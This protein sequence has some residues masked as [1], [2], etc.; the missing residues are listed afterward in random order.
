MESVGSPEEEFKFNTPVSAPYIIPYSSPYKAAVFP[1]FYNM[2]TFP[3]FYVTYPSPE[4]FSLASSEAVF[5]ACGNKGGG[6]EEEVM[7]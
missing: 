1:S 2:S 6:E 4:T 7:I 5:D 3:A